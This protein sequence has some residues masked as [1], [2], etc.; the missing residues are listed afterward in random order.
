MDAKYNREAIPALAGIPEYTF[1]LRGDPAEK[2]LPDTLIPVSDIYYVMNDELLTTQPDHPISGFGVKS[3]ELVSAAPK[4]GRDSDGDTVLDNEDDFPNDPSLTRALNPGYPGLWSLVFDSSEYAYMPFEKNLTFSLNKQ[5]IEG[6]CTNSPCIGLGNLSVNVTAQYD[7]IKAPAEHD[8]TLTPFDNKNTNTIGFSAFATVPGNYLIKAT[9]RA[10]SAEPVQAYETIVPIQ[11]IDPKSIEIRFNPEVPVPGQVTKVQ[12]KATKALCSL[13]T[14]CDALNLD[15]T[16]NNPDFVD[17]SLLADVFSVEQSLNRNGVK[18]NYSSVE[19]AGNDGSNVSNIELND[20]LDV[21]VRF[22]AGT[23]AFVAKSTNANSGGTQDSDSDG[24]ADT[25]DIFPEDANCSLEKDGIQ[26]TNLDGDINN[27][28]DPKCFA[29]F[30]ETAN[31]QFDVNFLNETWYY[32]KDWD[33]IIRK[34]KF[35]TGFNGLILLPTRQG[36]KQTVEHFKVDEISKRVYFGYQNA[37]IDYF[38]L[39]SQNIVGFDTGVAFVKIK[40]LNLVGTYL[41]AE[42]DLG[43]G[44]TSAKLFNKSGKLASI[45]GPEAF[46]KPLAAITLQIDGQNF[47]SATNNLLSLDWQIERT[48]PDETITFITPQLSNDR[49]T[50]LEGQTVYGDV[51]RL[52]LTFNAED[53]KQISLS[54][55]LFVLNFDD[56]GFTTEDFYDNQPVTLLLKNYDA[57]LLT[58]T[59]QRLYVNWYKNDATTDDSRY[60]FSDLSYPFILESS[61]FNFGDII[62]A[63]IMLSHGRKDDKD[64]KDILVSQKE[65]VIL[66]DLKELT[67]VINE[68]T[69]KIDLANL[70]FFFELE[71]LTPNNQFYTKQTFLPVWKINGVVIQGENGD[72]FPQLESTRLRYGDEISVS[73]SINISGRTLQT[74]DVVVTLIL[75]DPI[76][77]TFRIVPKVA[78]LGQ[79]LSL[80]KSVFTD[81]I[82]ETLE[83]RWRINSVVDKDVKSFTYP[84]DKLKYGDSVE[85]LILPLGGQL[86]SAFKYIA[87][88][89]VGLNLFSLNQVTSA[90]DDLDS[91]HDGIPNRQDFFRNDANCSLASEGYFDDI[92]RDGL[93]DLDE[94]KIYGTDPNKSD[95]DNDGLSDKDEIFKHSTNPLDA[96]S[97]DD[98]YRDGVEIEL[99]TLPLDPA[100]PIVIL[101]DSD[102]DGL[103]NDE[104]LK[105]GTR[106]KRFDTDADGLSDWFEIYGFR[107][108]DEPEKQT[109]PLNPDSDGDGL[110]DGLEVK[111]T[112]T[113]P[114]NAD[115]DNDGL[116]DGQEVMLGLNPLL[117]DSDNNGIND[118]DEPGYDFSQQLSRVLYISDL[119]NYQ[120][121]ADH[122]D[123]VEPGTCYNTFIGNDKPEFIAYSHVPQTSSTSLQ[124]VAFASSDWSQVLRYDARNKVYLPAIDLAEYPQAA[125]TSIEF[126][127]TDINKIY[128]GFSDGNIR[129]FDASDNSISN[130][131]VLAQGVPVTKLLDQKEKGL[132]IAEQINENGQIVHSAFNKATNST[133]AIAT[134][135][136]DYSYQNAIWQDSNRTTLLIIDTQ[137]NS[138]GFVRERFSSSLSNPLTQVELIASPVALTGPLFVETLSGNTLLR[139]GSGHSYNLTTSAWLSNRLSPFSYGLSHQSHRVVALKNSSLL[140]M[141]TRSTLD[142]SQF[143]RLTTQLD[144]PQLITVVPVGFHLLAVTSK[145]SSRIQSSAIAF[146]SILLGDE[147][148]NL[149][150]DWW[151]RLS[152]SLTPDDFNNYRLSG[153]V[154]VP[155]YLNGDPDIEVT[156]QPP[157]LLDSDNDGICDIWEINLFGTDPLKADTDNDGVS[158]GRELGIDFSKPLV[159]SAKPIF[160]DLSKFD[161]LDPDGF[162][163]DPLNP[164]TDGD[165]IV[166]GAL[167]TDGDNVTDTGEIFYYRTN[168]QLADTDGDGLTDYQEVHITNT[169]PLVANP[170]DTDS[171]GDKLTDVDEL[172]K[173]HTDHLHI[174][175]DRD[176]LTDYQEV[177]GLEVA[178]VIIPLGTNPNSK[179]TDGD[180]IEDNQEL[181]P[182]SYLEHLRDWNNDGVVDSRDVEKF[183]AELEK[184]KTNPAKS[185]TDGDGLSDYV[186]LNIS[187]EHAFISY[188]TVIDSDGDGLS[189]KV[190]FDFTFAYPSSAEGIPVDVLTKLNPGS[191]DTDKDGICDVWEVNL[192]KTNPAVKDTDFD[193]LTDPEELGLVEVKLVT[194]ETES[195]EETANALPVDCV[196]A[197][198]IEPISDPLLRDTDDDGVRDG[199]EVKKLQTDPRDM[200]SDD[201][202]ITDGNEDFDNDGLTNAQE[203]YLSK[204]FPRI[205]DSDGDGI[206]D[207]FDDQDGD[208]L[209]NIAE[210]NKHKTDPTKRDTNGDGIDDG[211]AVDL[212]LDPLKEDTDDDGVSDV[213][214]IADGTDPLNP[215]SDNDGL[216]DGEEKTKRTLPLIPDTDYDLLKDGSDDA[217]LVV[218][219]DRDGI[220]DGVE[221]NFLGT[222]PRDADTDNDGIPDGDE[223]WVFALKVIPGATPFDPPVLTQEYLQ[224][225]AAGSKVNLD[226]KRNNW[227]SHTLATLQNFVA[228]GRDRRVYDIYDMTDKSLI[229]GR[230][231]VQM[232]SNPA[233]A[234]SDGDGLTDATELAI[235]KAKGNGFDLDLPVSTSFSVLKSNAENFKLSDPWNADTNK[236]SDRDND[237]LPDWYEIKVTFTNLDAYD[238]NGNGISD[239]DENF[240]FDLLSNR[241]ELLF[242]SNPY[243]DVTLIDTDGDGLPDIYEVKLSET[244]P[245]KADT[246]ANGTPDGE[247]DFDNDGRN[248]LIEMY[249]QTDPLNVDTTAVDTDGDGLSDLWE[250]EITGT[251]PSVSNIKSEPFTIRN[252]FAWRLADLP[253]YDTDEDGLPDIYELKVLKTSAENNDSDSNGT[254]D[255]DEDVDQDGLSNLQEYFLM[256]N[257]LEADLALDSDGDGLSDFEEINLTLTDP[258]LADS[259]D[260]GVS[261]ALA[262]EDNDGVSNLDEVRAGSNPRT[263]AASQDSDGDGLSDFQELTITGTDPNNPFSLSS[264][265]NDADYDIDEDGLSNLLEV[266]LGFDPLTPDALV[267]DTDGDGLAD[268]IEVLL[269]LTDPNRNDTDGNGMSDFNDD[270][271][272]DGLSNSE[273]YFLG[274]DPAVRNI[275]ADT[276]KDGLTDFQETA[277]TLTDP[278]KVDSDNNG[279]SDGLEN[280]DND[281]YNNLQEMLALTDPYEHD[282]PDGYEDADG[283]WLVNVLD[284]NNQG[285]DVLT[286]DTDGDGIPDGIEVLILGTNP[287]SVDTDNDGISDKNELQLFNLANIRAVASNQACL[288]TETRLPFIAGQEYCV[289]IEFISYPTLADSDNDGTPDSKANPDNSV[290]LDHFPLDA[291]CSAASDGFEN[292]DIGREQCFSSWMSESNDI[293]VIQASEWRTSAE[294]QRA[295]ILFYNPGWDKIIRFNTLTSRYLA[296]IAV[297]DEEMIVGL[298]TVSQSRSLFIFYSDARLDRYDL[299]TGVTQTVDTLAQPGLTPDRMLALDNGDLLV[300][301][302]DAS[303]LSS[304]YIYNQNGIDLDNL[305]GLTIDIQES[306]ELCGSTDCSIYS[307]DK[308]SNGVNTNLA[309]IDIDLSAGVFNPTITFAD[310]LSQFAQLKGPIRISQDKSEIDPN[311]EREVYLASGQK[312][313]NDLLGSVHTESLNILHEGISYTNFY[314]FLESNDH[315]IGIVDYDISAI[316]GAPAVRATRNGLVASD[317]NYPNTY[318]IPPVSFEERILRLL[319]YE[320]TSSLDVAVV[321]K[322]SGSVLIEMLGLIDKD[323]DGM[324]GIYENYYGLN[325]EDASDKFKDP[326]TDGLTNI[327]EYRLGSDPFSDKYGDPDKDGLSN[328]DEHIY[329]TDPLN[330]DTDGDDFNDLEEILEGTDPNDATSFPDS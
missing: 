245:L 216:N 113:D 174:D 287:S 141:T 55:N 305:S 25:V 302:K 36:T 7:L 307:F 81:D 193:D 292:A 227:P 314:D 207:A 99:K 276:D 246:D 83:A 147:D 277:I 95:T 118:P 150:P 279:K 100:S 220:P 196:N 87:K 263:S 90:E 26:D 21:T 205:E 93:S 77:S 23:R 241:E 32:H 79:S 72:S 298:D 239:G 235:E 152:S 329:G 67:P 244:D 1:L 225:G 60:M 110:A 149:M 108:V 45:Q 47:L 101:P 129:L 304:L 69:L 59:K 191:Q 88:A 115:S 291:S 145:A 22:S 159:C 297:N 200:D 282:A 317:N 54:E 330:P 51:I 281:P 117:P 284:Q 283:D 219:T 230:L 183:N 213:E 56:I 293:A 104:E 155:D 177:I 309:K 5:Q 315:V 198:Q 138:N 64:K 139:F 78:D 151:Q 127:V 323:G 154:N 271:D 188:P 3:N 228:N 301:Y 274:T 203:L 80:D 65:I 94:I 221:A 264:E 112:G 24:V 11:V 46:S 158:D 9:F 229:V 124:Q 20:V 166:D 71:E 254:L 261:D 136:S 38:Q 312:L 262:D 190:E 211:D 40:S 4:G 322:L 182:A 2:Y 266:Q 249:E 105:E 70:D 119:P 167:D 326:D 30:F 313:D 259:D 278:T 52:K 248:N 68:D 321:S 6:V 173:Y 143:W 306:A 192:F 35:Q 267:R 130:K 201:N 106:V 255:S 273:E 300:Q 74:D 12:F 111:V 75:A 86:S 208:G 209:T 50:L 215:D 186:E 122:R 270:S 294:Q 303:N 234:D 280:F 181:N 224:V 16:D 109:N 161:P 61:N 120:V 18:F 135:S 153:N 144:Q 328:I 217:P 237:G 125:L 37:A 162:V 325:D 28:D 285:T 232:F 27:L 210:I 92:D 53:Q 114:F 296:P 311:D 258:F 41:L 34:N 318:L 218:D 176:G 250:M 142:D 140:E 103:S 66:G 252:P 157:V 170:L 275:A 184:Y 33:Y 226:N 73:Y 242:G 19:S 233:K 131:Y 187:G 269:T 247:E 169:N 197:P 199:D 243:K 257:P 299:E 289:R 164:D 97:D 260:D 308:D 324:T 91:D 116:P 156:V 17:I 327:E 15:L 31:V 189:D 42:Y 165:G 48:N 212:G 319:S 39:E 13:Y 63:D 238:S 172:N 89:S 180:G 8:F 175:T 57:S 85:L 265:V 96:D 185:D 134:W 62:R 126:D 10:D 82:L 195:S 295:D 133:T 194:D 168:P 251:D 102:F 268:H 44:N 43:S 222:S 240:D 160:M 14:F 123:R 137:H 223:A 316:P 132:L 98:G 171:D 121:I 272:N 146:Q 49:V 236:S 107:T 29:S 58:G 290:T 286:S 178:G 179:D 76:E 206:L 288:D 84:S 128:L 310:T 204:T 202:G 320:K 253:A 256:T 214:E 163:S 148:A 231:F